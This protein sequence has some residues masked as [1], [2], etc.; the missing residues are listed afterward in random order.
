S[1]DFVGMARER[2]QEKEGVFQ[3]YFTGCAGDV[4][5]GKYN[6]GTPEAR[7]GLYER[8]LAGME[9][10]IA[11]TT[12]MP[13]VRPEWR[14]APVLLLVR[15]DV[16]N[17]PADRQ[18]KLLDATI[19][20]F[21]RTWH[22]RRLAFAQ[23][24]DQPIELSSLRMGRICVVHLP[25]EPMVDYQLYAQRLRPDDFVAVAGYGEGCPSYIC[26][27]EAFAEGGYEPAA[28]AVAPES[29]WPLKAAIR[30]LTGVE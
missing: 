6:D 17:A 24:A 29:E 2:L 30:Q 22:A 7:Q 21:I 11:S 4:A 1:Y 14:T 9:A 26:T 12:W 15:Q 13:A 28:S 27:E 20:P 8:L 23:R 19:N 3:V 10:S 5:A 16:G 25:G 18:A